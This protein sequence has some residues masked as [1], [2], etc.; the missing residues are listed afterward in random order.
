MVKLVLN[1]VPA[2]TLLEVIISMVVMMAVFTVAIAIFTKVT[3]SGYSSSKVEAQQQMQIVMQESIENRDWQNG[4]LVVDSIEY[5][6]RVSNYTGYA[7][8]FLVTLEA[9]QQDKALGNLIRIVK[10]TKNEVAR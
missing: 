6:K 4:V 3:Q 7:D 8:L 9:K 1:R 5:T 10:K 2:S